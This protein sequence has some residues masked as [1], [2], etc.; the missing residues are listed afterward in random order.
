MND[1]LQVSRGGATLVDTE[2]VRQAATGFAG[3]AV[4]CA[5]VAGELELLAGALGGALGAALTWDD[6]GIAARARALAVVGDRARAEAERLAGGLSAAAAAYERV[7]LEAARAAALAAG[8]EGLARLL[9]GRLAALR[10]TTPSDAPA[11][12]LG[13]D[14]FLDRRGDLVA[15]WAQAPPLAPLGAAAVEAGI[16][17]LVAVERM[18]RGTVAASAR[19]HGAPPAVRVQPVAEG[20]DAAAAAPAGLAAAATRVPHTGE[21]RVRVERYTMADGTRQFAVYVAGTRSIGPSATEPWDLS[22]NVELYSGERSAS[23]QATVEA[24]RAAGADSGDTVHAFGYSQGGMIAARLALEGE[25]SVDTLVTFGS[26]V[27]VD[28]GSGTLS[29]AL[30]HSDDPVAALVGEG[31]PAGVGAPGSFVAERLGDPVGGVVDVIDPF[32]AHRLERYAETAGMLD[33]SA[34]PRM[35]AVRGVI[36]SLG[37]AASVESTEFAAERVEPAQSEPVRS[38]PVRSDHQSA[39]VAYR[40]R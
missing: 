14:D 16:V 15:Q 25:F 38:E 5:R 6:G 32:R 8:D 24:L 13:G 21:G 7:E 1:D 36:R 39:S 9:G 10:L 26:P 12:P 30:R 28:V 33:A 11:L 3:A 34:D 23:Y 20:A 29:V 37:E 19:L 35:D 4:A 40:G 27:T 31:F 17:G 22:S 2:S 18:G